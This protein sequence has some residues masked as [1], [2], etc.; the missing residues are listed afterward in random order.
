MD[1]ILNICPQ[2]GYALNC[3]FAGEKW[4]LNRGVGMATPL[5][6]CGVFVVY[7]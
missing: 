2:C 6:H 3:N 4:G 1:D 5:Q 7:L